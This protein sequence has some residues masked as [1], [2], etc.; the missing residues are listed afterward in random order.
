MKSSKTLKLFFKDSYRNY[1]CVDNWLVHRIV[2]QRYVD[3][4][5][6]EAIRSDISLQFRKHILS[7]V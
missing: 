6:W 2:V 1:K 3:V 4:R 7:A 5:L